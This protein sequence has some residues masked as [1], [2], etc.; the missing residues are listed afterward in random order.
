MNELNDLDKLRLQ[1]KTELEGT[2]SEH[3]VSTSADT[4][5]QKKDQA[6]AYWLLRGDIPFRDTHRGL[7]LFSEAGWIPYKRG[8][9]CNSFYIGWDVI[10][11]YL[12]S[13]VEKRN[14]ERVVG[15]TGLKKDTILDM[16]CGG[17]IFLE[18]VSAYYGPVLNLDLMGT[19]LVLP[20]YTR[21]FKD[22][23]ITLLRGNAMDIDTPLKP[24]DGYTMIIANQVVEYYDDPLSFLQFGRTNLNQE[25]VFFI[26]HSAVHRNIE[27]YDSAR[28]RISDPC[29]FLSEKYEEMGWTSEPTCMGDAVLAVR[30]YPDDCLN[31]EFINHNVAK[32]LP[33]FIEG[34]RYYRML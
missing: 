7:P 26:S 29:E 14:T 34:R 4:Q 13:L 15:R 3:Y 5:A 23:G 21:D 17:G 20:G 33:G 6:A 10:I 30:S 2:R 1:S 8:P 31:L 19:T 24:P 11:R 28:Q 18:D 22:R 9:G 12:D 16:G 32:R 25:G 27:I